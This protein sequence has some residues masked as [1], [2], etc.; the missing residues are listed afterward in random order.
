MNKLINNKLNPL[1][2]EKELKF[3][4]IFFIVALTLPFLVLII[5]TNVGISSVS[6]YLVQSNVNHHTVNLYYPTGEKYKTLNID[7]TWPLHG[8]VT[9]EFGQIDL[10][11]Q[12]LHTGIDIA[13]SEGTPI[14]AA[15]SGVVNYAGEINWGYGKHVIVDN[16]DGVQTLYG[17]L[18]SL[19]VK[20]GDKVIVGKTLI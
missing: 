17:H 4:V 16:G 9:L 3:I 10:P 5:I 20:K 8:V 2:L 19:A 1:S 7:T 11:Y 14:V 18:S 6:N 15:M 13:N 12:P